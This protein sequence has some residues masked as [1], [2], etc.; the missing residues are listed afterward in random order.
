MSTTGVRNIAIHAP[1]SITLKQ[2]KIDV[3]AY[4]HD[5]GPEQIKNNTNLYCGATIFS[6]KDRNPIVGIP[7]YAANCPGCIHKPQKRAEMDAM[8]RRPLSRSQESAE[9]LIVSS[10]HHHSAVEICESP[11]SRGSDFVSTVEGLFCDMATKTLYPLCGGNVE[12]ECFDVKSHELKFT[13]RD[14][15]V[16]WRYQSISRWD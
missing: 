9:R 8:Q 6:E 2:M 5:V 7:A 10:S 4:G 14:A 1:N 16:R 15:A 12:T 11:S 13:R 3:M